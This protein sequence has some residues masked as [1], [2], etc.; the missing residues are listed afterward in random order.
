[1]TDAQVRERS[2]LAP[3]EKE[4]IIKFAKG[5]AARI[6]SEQRGIIRRLLEHPEV[7]VRS[8]TLADG[9]RCEDVGVL[10]ESDTI[11]ALEATAPVG[12][13]KV[14]LTPRESD[15]LARVVSRRAGGKA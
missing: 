8:V 11:T 5:G 1:M 15:Q 9:S 14:Q 2:A 7:S 3:E 10:G 4:T 13:L 12:L 6:F